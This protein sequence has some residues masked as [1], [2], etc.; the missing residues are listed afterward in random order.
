MRKE[1][2]V[3]GAD[4]DVEE[5]QILEA[6]VVDT[7]GASRGV[8]LPLIA[9][10][11]ALLAIILAGGGVYYS[12]QS[13]DLVM[14]EFQALNQELLAA[15]QATQ[16]VRE[17]IGSARAAADAQSQQLKQQREALAAQQQALGAHKEVLAAQS[18]KLDEERSRLEQAGSEIREAIQSLH[19]RIGSD[20]NQW[21]ASEAAYLIQVANHR[22][23]LEWD[24][25]TA[26]QALQEA[27]ARLR[28][29]GDPSWIPVR[30]ILALEISSLRS[31]GLA[32]IEG[33][34]LQLAGLAG[35]IEKL[36][37]LGTEPLPATRPGQPEAKPVASRTWK[38]LIE[39]GWAGFKSIMVIR[40]HGQ[41]VGA[42]VPPDQQLFL[43]QNLRLQ[44]EAARI[45][46]LRGNQA[47]YDTSLQTA[48]QLLRD[49]FD[50]DDAGVG[51]Y[52]GEIDKLGKIRV[53]PELPDISASLLALRDTLAKT[54][55]AQ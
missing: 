25:Q 19:R 39:D 53:R 33:L 30:E 22:L 52:L 54:G 23:H 43:Q 5:A 46:L 49:H 10:A 50:A 37:M 12:Q 2:T 15:K 44:L 51:N 38:T 47:L 24:A 55:G 42:M 32:D 14:S 26:I 6:E 28:D 41:P 4:N 40:H 1:E 11:L 35:G 8:G 3:S 20:N 31:A 48:V 7:K 16:A 13:R 17:E 21:M 45:S 27:D 36:K 9:V 34:A 18:G 29:S